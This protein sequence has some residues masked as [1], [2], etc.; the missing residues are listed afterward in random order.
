MENEC[1]NENPITVFQY[2]NNNNIDKTIDTFFS[3]KRE[4]RGKTV[5]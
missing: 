5:V 3:M 1:I 4:A 2:L